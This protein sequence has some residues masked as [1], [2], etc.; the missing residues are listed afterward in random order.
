MGSSYLEKERFDGTRV[1]FNELNLPNEILIG[2]IDFSETP[3]EIKN[4]S[5]VGERTIFKD[6]KMLCSIIDDIKE[7]HF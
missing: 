2:R 6:G 7:T 1:T 5:L 4:L 3:N